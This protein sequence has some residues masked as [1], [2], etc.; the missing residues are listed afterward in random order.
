MSIAIVLHAL[1][2]AVW[3]GGMFFAWLCL[4]PALGVV[5]AAARPQLWVAVF[6][7][8]FPYVWAALVVLLA[9]G[10]YLIAGLGGM[11]RVSPWVHVMLGLGIVMMLLFLHVWFAPF[12]RLKRCVAAG[13]RAAAGKPLGQ[14][15]VLIGINLVLGLVTVACGALA[16]LYPVG[17]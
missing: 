4:R 9:T 1:S 12:R 13:D 7:R 10:F 11:A 2:A 14:I 16:S 17:P 8:F 5:D 3:V 6:G 15:R